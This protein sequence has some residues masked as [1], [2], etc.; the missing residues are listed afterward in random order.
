MPRVLIATSNEAGF[1]SMVSAVKDRELMWN[2]DT[3]KLF[4]KSKGEV[5]DIT[6]TGSIVYD[7]VITS[8]EEFDKM[9]Q[10]FDGSV[11]ILKGNYE[12]KQFP[13]KWRA[14]YGAGVDNTIIN[15]EHDI[16]DE[17]TVAFD[18]TDFSA[19]YLEKLTINAHFVNR[20]NSKRNLYIVKDADN[21]DDVR[22]NVN[23][24][25]KRTEVGSSSRVY[26][27]ALYDCTYVENSNVYVEYTDAVYA[28]QQR[29]AENNDDNR[30]FFNN[31]KLYVKRAASTEFIEQKDLTKVLTNFLNNPLLY[32][33]Q[34][35]SVNYFNQLIDADG[36]VG[37]VGKVLTTDKGG[38]LHWQDISEYI[39]TSGT[40][41]FWDRYKTYT[42][43]D[44]VAYIYVS[45]DNLSSIQF[46]K[47]TDASDTGTVPSPEISETNP[48][49]YIGPF[50]SVGEGGDSDPIDLSQF[51]TKEQ[52]DELTYEK[53]KDLE[54]K[55][56]I[57]AEAREIEDV[58]LNDRVTALEEEVSNTGELSQRVDNIEADVNTLQTN[59]NEA[60]DKIDFINENIESI[61][62]VLDSN[63]FIDIIE[64]DTEIN[65]TDET[66]LFIEKEGQEK[67]TFIKVKAVDIWNYISQKIKDN[68]SLEDLK[69]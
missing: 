39:D 15:F 57:E 38:S 49:E 32:V 1:N 66:T 23:L 51:I 19:S 40:L 65:I 58:L 29:L 21:I 4:I 41:Q 11:L 14:I 48:W 44:V 22:I 37:D 5:I 25:E 27:T 28:I 24:T 62:N 64:S 17:N 68:I 9:P 53:Y 16:V 69:Y 46:Y 10:E 55:I 6:K 35:S 43:G 56:N 31:T 47:L 30:G 42:K 67:P 50:G 59:I 12:C 61:E 54:N 33:Y 60:S 20:T 26:F 8:Q 13:L 7:K 52:L 63:S 18:F 34:T 3:K 45:E 36:Q 2:E